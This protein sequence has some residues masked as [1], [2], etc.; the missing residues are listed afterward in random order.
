MAD[1]TSMTIHQMWQTPF[2]RGVYSLL[3]TTSFVMQ[4]YY[5]VLN[6][7]NREFT[8]SRTFGW[9]IFNRT[10]TVG[11]AKSPM[12]PPTVIK[13]QKI[14]HQTG[15][16]LRVAEKMHFYEQE[17]MHLR[18]QGAPI[19][20]LD[21]KGMKWMTQ[22]ID[23]MTQRHRNLMELSF[24]RMLTGGF[25]LRSAGEFMFITELN[26]A[27]NE[28]NIDMGIPATHQGTL[29]G[30]IDKNWDDPTADIVGQLM[31]LKQRALAESG[32]DLAVMWT[33]SITA[34]HMMQNQTLSEIKGSVNRAFTTWDFKGQATDVQPG[35]RDLGA[36]MGIRFAALPWLNVMVNDAYLSL[37]TATD[38]QGTDSF[39][40]ADLTRVM[41]AGHAVFTPPPGGD[42]YTIFEGEEPIRTTYGGQST[43]VR[44]FGTWEFLMP[45]IPPGR[46]A[47]YLDNFL[48]VLRF[49]RAVW[50]AT[51]RDASADHN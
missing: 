50:D 20:T 42:W 24:A 8:P 16:L 25:G 51:V 5:G 4:R 46:E 33:D 30:I 44:G 18:P 14:G 29:D 7:Q 40:I 37:G 19:G 11:T 27:S 9:D 21:Q 41:P 12:S 17:Y 47:G 23:F 31:K 48:P 36:T 49:P 26:A 38:P 22:Q 34:G 32:F 2:V 45:N 1:T 35:D 13:R 15:A 6:Q 10:R 3:P 39:D 43:I 28:I